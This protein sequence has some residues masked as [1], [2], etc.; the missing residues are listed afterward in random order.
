[1]S[2]PFEA[3]VNPVACHTAIRVTDM[4]RSLHFYR[5]LI[6]LPVERTQG[7]LEN[8][9]VAWLPGVQLIHD[10]EARSVP[11]QTFDHLAF[12]IDNVEEVCQ[13]L[14]AAG[15]QAETPLQQ[16]SREDVGR[17]LTMAFYRDPDG[18]K[19]EVL[20]FDE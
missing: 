6:G 18:N 9:Q 2:Q 8:P 10:P 20:R 12:G 1:M 16:R 14:D 5:D 19:L 11:G 7:P 4:A 15:F 13:R 17:L 3:K